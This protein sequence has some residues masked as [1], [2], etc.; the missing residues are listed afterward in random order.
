MKP[1]HDMIQN[2]QM[3]TIGPLLDR[4]KEG[5]TAFDNIIAEIFKNRQIE[6]KNDD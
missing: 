3:K 4:T 5:L 1:L 6:D 2:Y